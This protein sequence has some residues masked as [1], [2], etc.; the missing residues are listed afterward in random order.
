MRNVDRLWM[1][2]LDA[3]TELKGSIGLNA[4]AQRNPIV[5]YKIQGSIMFDEMVQNI[6]DN[7]ATML[8][9]HAPRIAMKREQVAKITGTSAGGDGTVKKTPVKVK[10]KVGPNDPCPCGSGKKYKKCC[11]L[12]ESE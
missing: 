10:T 5:E 1:D 7:T 11:G 4:Y 9:S 6:R 12:K 8:L 2:H 3:M